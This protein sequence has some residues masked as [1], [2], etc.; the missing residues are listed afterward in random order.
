MG[1]LKPYL[2]HPHTLDPPICASTSRARSTLS[3][4]HASENPF[5][6]PHCVEHQTDVIDCKWGSQA[7]A[8]IAAVAGGDGH[9][10]PNP[11]RRAGVAASDH[12]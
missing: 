2:S 5:P 7:S 10:N 3:M 6:K 11:D 4:Q 12:L 9:D 1:Q 8:V